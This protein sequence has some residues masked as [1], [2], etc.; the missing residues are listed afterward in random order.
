VNQAIERPRN[1]G[2]PEPCVWCARAAVDARLVGMDKKLKELKNRYNSAGAVWD[3]M[4]SKELLAGL[5]T[6]FEKAK[7]SLKL[8]LA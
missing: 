2:C 3:A 1:G 4:P 8:F 6:Q 5:K 7:E